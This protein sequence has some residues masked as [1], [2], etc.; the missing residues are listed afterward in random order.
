MK[1]IFVTLLIMYSSVCFAGPKEDARDAFKRGDY[2]K[3]L[4]LRLPLAEAG[5]VDEL[6]NVG[7][8]Y[9]FAQGTEQN[10]EKAYSYWLRASEKHLGTAMGNIAVLYMTG[11]GPVE[12]N[13]VEAAKWYKRGAEHRHWQSMITL[14][15]M[16]M[17]GQGLE[18]DKATAIA[19]G[20]LAAS[21]APNPNAREIS[22]RQVRAMISESNETDFQKEKGLTERLRALID[23]NVRLYVNQ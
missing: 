10:Y 1:A 19:W 21:N 16:Y 7:N 14:S 5:D 4:E 20:A 12:K 23:E 9:S 11:K 17:L 22:E 2:Q 15:S 3:A 13:I 18:Q 6:G 8:M